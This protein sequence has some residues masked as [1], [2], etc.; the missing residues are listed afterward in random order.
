MC[1]IVGLFNRDPEAPINTEALWQMLAPIQNR[2]PNGQSV[3]TGRGVGLGHARL[4]ILDLDHRSD[5]PMVDKETGRVITFNGEIYNYLELREEL[6]RLG[7]RFTTTGDTEVILKAYDRWGPDCLSRFNG[8]WA[9]AIYDPANQTLFCARDRLGI[10][11]FVYGMDRR[12]LVF[13]SEAKAICA[14]FAKFSVPHLAFLRH[15]IETG[16]FAGSDTTFYRELKNLLPGHYFVVRPGE[17]P[18]PVRYWQWQPTLVTPMPSEAEAVEQFEA[19]LSDA[20]RLRFRSDVP[21]GV[22]LSGGLDSSSIVALASQLFDRPISTFS[23][24]YPGLP[25]LDESQYIRKTTEKFGCDAHLVEPAMPELVPMIRQS[26][27]EQDG[28]TGTPAVLSQRAVMSIAHGH[29]TVLLDGQ[30]ADELLGGY[31]SYFPQSL[32]TLMRRILQAPTPANIAAYWQAAKAIRDRT[33]A[34]C[35]KL[36]RILRHAGRPARF[37]RTPFASSQL[38]A[39]SPCNGDDLNTKLIEDLLYNTLPQLLHYEDRNS[40]AF[41]L[42]SRLPF[43]DYRLVEYLFSL[44]CSFKIKGARTKVLLYE[45]MKAKLP[46]EVLSR[47]DKMGYATPGQS[48]FTQPAERLA[49]TPYFEKVPLP[50]LSLDESVKN[51]LAQDWK[52]CQNRVPLAPHRERMIW[53]YLTACMWL[54]SLQEPPKTSYAPAQDALSAAAASVTP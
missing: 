16:N 4:S 31:H 44:P 43:L 35:E 7:Y 29:V 41:S 50:L 27:W 23:C 19:L 14:A 37:S 25:S 49:L 24:I 17:E 39:V 1:G 5:Q 8:M 12:Q 48:W 10:K 3:W 21:V 34:S 28:P 53:R 6:S 52:R 9:L 45:S 11:P 38:G 13:A 54:E 42:E 47:K 18:Q 36:S 46:P 40:M 26:I 20:I 30:G 22:C 2:G 51:T 32:Q 33:G 15:F